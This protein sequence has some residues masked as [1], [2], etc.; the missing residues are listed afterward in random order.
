VGTGPGLAA[1]RAVA[2]EAAGRIRIR[3]AWFRSDIA[4]TAAQHE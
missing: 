2:Y 4:A 3:G 1:A